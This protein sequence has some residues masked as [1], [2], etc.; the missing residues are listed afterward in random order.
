MLFLHPSTLLPLLFTILTSTH[1]S[2]ARP[3][4]DPELKHM[5]ETRYHYLAER[6]CS[7]PCGWSGQLCCTSGQ[8][9]STNSI[10]QAVCNDGSGGQANGANGN[11]QLY[12]TTFVE[13]EL[14]TVTSTYSSLYNAANTAAAAAPAVSAISCHTDLGESPC[15]T[16]CC[17]TGQYCVYSGN[18]GASNDNAAQSSSSLFEQPSTPTTNAAPLRPTSNVAT[19]VTSTGSATTTVPFMTPS[20]TSMAA[21]AS[22]D[23]GVSTTTN[24][25]LSGGAIAGIV[26]GVLLA[27]LFLL[28]LCIFCCLR[29]LADSILGFFGLSNRRKKREVIESEHYSRRGGRTWYGGKS[30]VDKPKKSGDGVGGLLGVGG[31]LATLAVILGL[32]RRH[33]NKKTK[34]EYSGSSYTYSDT[35]SSESMSSLKRLE[36]SVTNSK[37][38]SESSRSADRRTRDTRRSSG[39]R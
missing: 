6:Q 34:T 25:G 1:L 36:M 5:L 30:T 20:S 10:G 11:L 35:Y 9:C 31:A 3:P 14:T 17:A 4:P 33:D 22:G 7:N 21:A 23:A 13:N 27:I 8:T 18:C 19:T 2:E 29:G 15:G 26:I 24:N 12:T 37:P 32:K 16:L 38:G 28:L 39:R